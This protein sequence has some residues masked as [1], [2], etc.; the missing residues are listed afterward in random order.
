MFSRLADVVVRRYKLIIVVWIVALFYVFP[1]VFKVNSVVVYN[2]NEVGLNKLEA[3]EAGNVIAAQFPG[4]VP[5]SS[6]T[7]VIQ[8]SNMSSPEARTFVSALYE[9][10]TE[11][12]ALQGVSRVD[13]LYSAVQS[14]MEGVVGQAAPAMYL[15]AA[16]ANSTSM[17]VFGIP[18]E[19]V[20]KH[21]ALLAQNYSDEAAKS[22][23]IQS[24]TQELVLAGESSSM[25]SL[26][27]GYIEEFY[28]TWTRSGDLT[29]ID[30]QIV[31]AANQY[32]PMTGEVGQFA[33]A[34]AQG[35]NVTDFSSPL[36]QKNFAIGVVSS[37][38]ESTFSFGERVWDL[39]PSPSVA[40]ITAFA[41]SVVFAYPVG[42]LPIVVPQALISQF[43]NIHSA[44]GQSN[45]TM[46]MAVS[47]AVDSSSKQASDDVKA[48][49]VVAHSL[50]S[51][52]PGFVVYVSGD[53]AI[54]VD[55]QDAVA[56]D[57][58]KID[59]AT[60]ILV[61]LFVGLFFRSAVSPWIP[62]VTVGLA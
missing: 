10:I 1:L 50:A 37:Q 38:T 49:R 41:R 15:L 16:Q 47:L 43:V 20:Q 33:L 3:V 51:S 30:E 29:L 34:V 39:G 18:L 53:P 59:P 28:A 8:N 7:I 60:I 22:I 48:L 57:T 23:T 62:L 45:S 42:E 24:I 46:L 2:E 13:Y 14:Y 36:A 31:A 32:F 40:S 19:V 21:L 6:I 27:V 26:T 25:V 61:L 4:H 54:N 5:T 12:G 55:T 17:L 9:N 35:L 52:N 58:S 44:T 11:D 56:K